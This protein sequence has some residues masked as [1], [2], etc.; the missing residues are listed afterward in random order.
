MKITR[1]S[2]FETTII[3]DLRS[4]AAHYSAVNS[5]MYTR[6]LGLVYVDIDASGEGGIW[7][8]LGGGL[9]TSGLLHLDKRIYCW[10]NFCN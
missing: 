10:S 3:N 7:G 1:R 9:H 4:T 2:V 8:I 5:D 6:I